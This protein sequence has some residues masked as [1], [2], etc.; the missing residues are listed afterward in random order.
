MKAR[1]HAGTRGAAP[2]AA[3]N[4]RMQSMAEALAVDGP[5]RDRLLKHAWLRFGV[6]SE[7]AADCLQDTCLALL[8]AGDR[9]RNPGA[10]AFAVF[11]RRCC[12]AMQQAKRRDASLPRVLAAQRGECEDLLDVRRAIARLSPRRRALLQA[13]YI[14][15]H[16]LRVTGQLCRVREA[17][18]ATLL[19]RAVAVLRARLVG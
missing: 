14:E 3:P 7:D 16:G 5:F 9:V 10:F 13:Y 15:G 6:Q 19:R 2:W 17:S 4:P 8:M 1:T 12:A 11:H 18:A